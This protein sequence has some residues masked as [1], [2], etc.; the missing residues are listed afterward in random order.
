MKTNKGKTKSKKLKPSQRACV[1]CVPKKSPM[2]L[3]ICPLSEL[4]SDS[5]KIT[6]SPPRIQMKLKPRSASSEA[7]RRI[8][9][10]GTASTRSLGAT[11]ICICAD[12]IKTDQAGR[13]T[14]QQ[15]RP[16]RGYALTYVN[17]RRFSVPDGGHLDRGPVATADALDDTEIVLADKRLVVV[18]PRGAVVERQHAGQRDGEYRTFHVA[19]LRVEIFR[20]PGAG[21]I[22]VGDPPHAG[23]VGN[24]IEPGLGRHQMV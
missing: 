15:C 14:S 7:I 22:D 4:I 9:G 11:C 12:R 18:M 13:S 5:A 20:Q 21:I 3:T 8:A 10:T 23:E 2:P 16:N 1:S 17:R 19:L 24:R 6:P